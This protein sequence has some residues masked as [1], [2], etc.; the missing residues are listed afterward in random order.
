M[1]G[2]GSLGNSYELVYGT[3]KSKDNGCRYRYI[4]DLEAIKATERLTLN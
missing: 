1:K 4:F 2:S 3:N